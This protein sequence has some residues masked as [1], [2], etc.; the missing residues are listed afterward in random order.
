MLEFLSVPAPSDMYYREGLRNPKFAYIDGENTGIVLIPIT[1]PE[2]DV[3]N[4]RSEPDP[5]FFDV[6]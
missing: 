1:E 6:E 4:R 3:L 5:I 2:S